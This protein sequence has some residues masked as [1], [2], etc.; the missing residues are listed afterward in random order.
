MAAMTSRL[1]GPG[2]LQHTRNSIDLT[3]QPIDK[4]GYIFIKKKLKNQV[5][6]VTA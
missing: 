6:S 3:N 2:V 4:K 5:R 1:L